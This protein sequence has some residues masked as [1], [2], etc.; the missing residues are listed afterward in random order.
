M[1][2]A[3]IVFPGSNC[4]TDAARAITR[5]VGEPADLVWHEAT[6][7][8]GYDAVIVPGGFAFGDYLRAGAI[9]RF[10]PVMDAVRGHA[11]AGRPLLGICNGFQVLT[12]AGLLP[13]V[14]LPNASL[15]FRCEF[16]TLRVEN[17]QTPFTRAYAAEQEICLPIAH[18]QGSYYADAPMLEDLRRH[19][20]IVFRY[21]GANPNGSLDDIAGIVNRRGNVLGMMPHPERAVHPLLGSSDGAALFTSLVQAWGQQVVYA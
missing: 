2:F 17:A 8:D 9:A 4:D 1:R 19:H 5:V 18:G 10:S 20:Q 21:R 13:G 3:V 6:S 12:E 15:Q 14:L 16:V 11:E 7:L